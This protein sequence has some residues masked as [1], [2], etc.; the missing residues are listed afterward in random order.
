MILYDSLGNEIKFGDS[1]GSGALAAI[2]AEVVVT[3]NGGEATAYLDLRGTFVM[4]VDVQGSVDGVNY[5]SLPIESQAT[6]VWQLGATTVGQYVLQCAGVKFLRAR[7]T[8]WT[9]GT[10]TTTLKA[11]KGT[12]IVKA[13]LHPSTLSVTVT[14][15]AAA[16]ATLTL[17]AVAGLYHY[18]TR[19]IVQRFAAALLTAAATPVLV[20]TTNLPGTRVLSFPA[21]AAAQGTMYTEE[22]SP[23]QP[24]KSSAAGGATTV[25]MPITTGVIWRA[26]ADYYLG[27]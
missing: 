16:A 6:E 5:F 23:A 22:I 25:V 4:T 2:N 21:E 7:V 1:A 11:S 18:V 10:A 17:P 9:S 14:A 19:I 8:A 26:T 13:M 24:L 12:E 20:T 15:A 27:A 3:L